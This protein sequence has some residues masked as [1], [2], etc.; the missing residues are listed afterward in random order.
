MRG[1][2][3]SAKEREARKEEI[4]RSSCIVAIG[5]RL[6]FFA[7]VVICLDHSR[8]S[9]PGRAFEK[10]S[11]STVREREAS[12]LSLVSFIASFFLPWASLCAPK[13]SLT[14]YKDTA[15]STLFFASS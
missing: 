10:V 7:F 15:P 1:P 3:T 9:L 4:S 2:L 5:F 13:S 8:R 11:P 12:S 14:Y 6:L